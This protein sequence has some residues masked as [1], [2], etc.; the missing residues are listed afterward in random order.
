MA[1]VDVIFP[2]SSYLYTYMTDLELVRDD[3]VLTPSGV[4]LFVK[5]GKPRPGI[6]YKRLL[7]KFVDKRLTL[8]YDKEVVKTLQRCHWVRDEPMCEEPAVLSWQDFKV[9]FKDVV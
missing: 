9:R 7:G 2:N 6:T 5:P 4:A 1:Y 8:P 3:Y